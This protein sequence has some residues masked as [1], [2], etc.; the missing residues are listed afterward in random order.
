MKLYPFIV[1]F[2]VGLSLA[3]AAEEPTQTEAPPPEPRPDGVRILTDYPS[4]QAA[5]DSLHEGMGSIYVPAGRHVIKRTINLT[6]AAGYGGGVKIFG[7]GR[8]SRLVGETGGQPIFDLS[9]ASHCTMYDLLIESVDANVGFLLARR[10]DGWAAQE[11]R[12]VRLILEG[13]FSIANVYNMTSELVRFVDCIFMNNAPSS[14]NLVWTHDNFANLTSPY[15]GQIREIFSNTELRIR[16]CTFYNWGGGE[17]GANLYLRGYAQDLVVRD[18]Y[19][20]PPEGGH[21]VY[22]TNSRK[23]GGVLCVEVDGVRIEA[24]NASDVFRIEG[25]ADQ[26]SVRNCS[27]FYGEA[28]LLNADK[29]TDLTLE[30]NCF[31][32]IRGWKTGARADHL[33]RAR[34]VANRWVFDNWGGQNPQDKEPLVIY[35]T[36]VEDSLIEV[37]ERSLVNFQEMH[38]TVI[39]ALDDGEAG[40]RRRYLGDRASGTVLNLTPVDTS[41]LTDARRGDLALDDGTNTKSGKP[42]LAVFDGET[43]QSMN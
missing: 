7:A 6:R 22:I 10:Q 14:Y 17:K 15:V 12:F 40:T 25:H 26:I 33:S 16:G 24:D 18:G 34:I 39:E 2:I 31:W 21:A 19:M 20:N 4:L 35:G 5:V 8:A 37:G 3:A 27:V 23:G 36:S 9:G 29:V 41:G 43:W 11:H 30:E 1:P 38:G 32:N 13:K 42:G 28:L